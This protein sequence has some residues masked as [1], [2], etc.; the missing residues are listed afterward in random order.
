[1]HR[2][3][4]LLQALGLA[5]ASLTA[6]GPGEAL[7]AM[8][9]A[10]PPLPAS[11]STAEVRPGRDALPEAEAVQF[12]RRRARVVVVRPRSRRVVVVRPR[13]RVIVVRR[14]RF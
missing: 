12:R 8:P 10:P 6:V 4:F 2:R 5:A 14:R 1:M 9:L 11:P 13:R 3:T 7:A